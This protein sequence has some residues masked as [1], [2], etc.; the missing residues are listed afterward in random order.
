MWFLPQAY[1]KSIDL[2]LLLAIGVFDDPSLPFSL[3]LVW[4][5]PRKLQDASYPEA[6]SHRVSPPANVPTL[7][8]FDSLS[9]FSRTER[10]IR[11]EKRC[12]LSQNLL[13]VTSLPTF[14]HFP[15]AFPV[16]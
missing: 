1:I 12:G 6:V 11:E 16:P 8:G 10:P 4:L 15:I 5:R 13:L 7:S 9:G 2:H 14:E 3:S